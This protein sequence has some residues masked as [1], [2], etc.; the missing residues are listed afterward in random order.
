MDSNDRLITLK[1]KELRGVVR[2]EFDNALTRLGVDVNQP[3]EMQAD[4]RWVRTA[5]QTAGDIK[6]KAVTVVAG[7]VITAALGM[8]WFGFKESVRAEEPPPKPFKFLKI[9]KDE[10]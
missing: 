10:G 2:E 7:T 4:L 6:S 1:E 9:D 8:L 5:R 3:L